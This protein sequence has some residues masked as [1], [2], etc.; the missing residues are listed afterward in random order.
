MDQL[1][2][3]RQNRSLHLLVATVGRL[4]ESLPQLEIF[5]VRMMSE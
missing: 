5:D 2:A 4:M 3:L 1:A